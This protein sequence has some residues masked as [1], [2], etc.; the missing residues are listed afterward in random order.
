MLFAAC[1]TAGALYLSTP[2]SRTDFLNYSTGIDSLIKITLEQHLIPPQSVRKYT[3]PVD[4]TFSRSVYRVQV[5]A[6]FPKTKF[7][8]DLHHNVK[9]Y[10]LSAPA[11]FIVPDNSMNIYIYDSRNV[12]S[13]IRL[14][15]EKQA[16]ENNG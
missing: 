7:H 6:R 3:I 15:T 11:Q 5:P 13:T 10:N 9:K 2:V 16:T 8:M 12:R 4:S 1:L 14:I